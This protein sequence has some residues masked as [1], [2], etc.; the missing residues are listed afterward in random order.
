MIEFKHNT[1]CEYEPDSD[2]DSE[3]INEDDEDEF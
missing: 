2:L 3:E 1:T